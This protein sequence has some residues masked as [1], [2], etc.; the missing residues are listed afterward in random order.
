MGWESSSIYTKNRRLILFL[1]KKVPFSPPDITESEVNLV[2][3]ALRSGWITTGPKTKEFERKIAEY[4]HTDYAVCL[5]SA[6]ACM[7]SILRVLGV[8]SGDEVITCAYTYTA[9]ASVT[10]HVG[11]KVVMVDTAPGSFEMDYDKLAEAITPNTK[12]VIPVDLGGVMCDY[13]RIYAAVES[14]RHL[15]NPANE[16]Q[17]VFGRVIVLADA[18]HAFGAQWHGKMCGEVADFTSFSFHAVKNLTT[19]EGG[20][21]TWRTFPNVDNEA[22]YRQFQL[23]SLHGQNKDALAKTRLGAWEY[24]IIA[25]YYKCNM[26]DIMAAI[27]LVQFER[28]EGMLARRQEIIRRYNEALKPYHTQTLNHLDGDHVS[29]GHLYLVRLLDKSM[30][31][32]ND[33][34]IKM[35]ERGIACNVHY[36]PLPMMTAYKALGF[37]IADYPNAYNQYHNE[38]TLPLHTCLTD[39]DVEYVITNFVDIISK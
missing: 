34:I 14:K 26:T 31:Q 22:L 27:G 35:A 29:S 8:G 18:A 3:D 6:T 5:N 4:C 10:C 13:D 17:K 11:A 1:M 9:T 25:P 19:A 7:E 32:R 28:Y 39:E 20:A 21:L 30:E 2:S 15:F 36:K 24:D 38:I 33:I 37:D 23:L 12:V 16:I